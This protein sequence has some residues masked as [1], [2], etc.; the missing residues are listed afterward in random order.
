MQGRRRGE[1][2]VMEEEGRGDGRGQRGGRLMLL[3]LLLLLMMEDI[4]RRGRWRR[5]FRRIFLL[6]ILLDGR[7]DSAGW[8]FADAADDAFADA[9]DDARGRK[10]EVCRFLFCRFFCCCRRRR[11]F[12]GGGGVDDVDDGSPAVDRVLSEFVLRVGLSAVPF[13]VA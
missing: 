13:G 2:A 6:D 4:G 3:L 7:R 9:A 5:Q 12:V 11:R 1:R 8:R 10:D